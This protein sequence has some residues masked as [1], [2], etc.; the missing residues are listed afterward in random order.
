MVER[1]KKIGEFHERAF[2]EV[3]GHFQAA[4]GP[5]TGRWFD[6]AFNKDETEAARATRL[7]A[8][9]RLELPEAPCLAPT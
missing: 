7:V 5:Y 1:E 8:H 6:E 4:A 9:F 3:H 2:F